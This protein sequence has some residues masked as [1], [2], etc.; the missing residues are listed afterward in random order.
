MC[1]ENCSGDP[2]HTLSQLSLVQ[3]VAVAWP[4]PSQDA[5]LVFIDMT[6]VQDSPLDL[7][8]TPLQN[9]YQVGPLTWHSH[10]LESITSWPGSP[11][12]PDLIVHWQGNS[13]ALEDLLSM[14]TWLAPRP[15]CLVV[16]QSKKNLLVCGFDWLHYRI[17]EY[18]QERK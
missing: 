7:D 13:L 10:V 11:L 6:P 4:C 5:T 15:S 8:R 2:A 3:I 1:Y 14:S 12:F 18:V 16:A 17:Q 9:L